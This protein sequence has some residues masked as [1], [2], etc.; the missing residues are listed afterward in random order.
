[1]AE[2]SGLGCCPAPGCGQQVGSTESVGAGLKICGR[3]RQVAYCSRNCQKAAWKR[4]HKKECEAL[5]AACDKTQ[6]NLRVRDALV[7]GVQACMLRVAE[8][9]HGFGELLFQPVRDVLEVGP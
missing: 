4:G 3:C 2:F 7:R 6:A 5:Q 9:E 1:M 8:L